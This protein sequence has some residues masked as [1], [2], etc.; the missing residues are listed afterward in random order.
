M[1]PWH[2][3]TAAARRA[4]DYE[5][6][7]AWHVA[8][9]CIDAGDVQRRSSTACTSV[10]EQAKMTVGTVMQVLSMLDKCADLRSKH[11]LPEADYEKL[12]AYSLDW[13]RFLSSQAAPTIES[14]STTPCEIT[15]QE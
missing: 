6:S 3:H 10:S 5:R 8:I 12:R 1:S 11:V 15:G 13:L 2:A 7:Q 4:S 14:D 9:A